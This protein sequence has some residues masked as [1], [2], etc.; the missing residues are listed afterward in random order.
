MKQVQG[1]D[2]ADTNVFDLILY[3]S[4]IIQDA[5]PERVGL[6]GQMPDRLKKFSC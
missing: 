1:V 6:P 4:N 2:L 3:L 5:V